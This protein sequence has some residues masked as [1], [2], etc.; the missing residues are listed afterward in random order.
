MSVLTKAS[1]VE[2][3]HTC[4]LEAV[5]LCVQEHRHSFKC[6]VRA[7]GKRMHREDERKA[8]NLRVR[9]DLASARVD[10]IGGGAG[11]RLDA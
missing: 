11:V 9:D 3:S 10:V 1:R 6:F 7:G 4:V 5:F 2:I 8:T